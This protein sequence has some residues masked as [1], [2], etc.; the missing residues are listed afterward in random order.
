MLDQ[1]RRH[2]FVPP[3]DEALSAM[4]EIDLDERLEAGIVF[5][6]TGATGGARQWLK[7]TPPPGRLDGRSRK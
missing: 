7:A 5:R 1:L 2:G 3:D 6:Y 4:S